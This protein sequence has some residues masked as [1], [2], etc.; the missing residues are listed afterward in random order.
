MG[1]NVH[2][3]PKGLAASL[4]SYL[5]K[6]FNLVP[7]KKFQFSPVMLPI[8]WA[9]DVDFWVHS[10]G[11]YR[12]LTT[13]PNLKS[14]LLGFGCELPHKFTN[15]FCRNVG[16]ILAERGLR[17]TITWHSGL[18][19]YPIVSLLGIGNNEH[20]KQEDEFHTKVVSNLLGHQRHDPAH[21]N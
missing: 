6:S 21:H 12:L 18:L 8:P 19:I 15:T 14:V 9:V 20:I 10:V 7:T 4:T 2:P 13:W 11:N 17:Y 5:F 1:N 16:N 3:K